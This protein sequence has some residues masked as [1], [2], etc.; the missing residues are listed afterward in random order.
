M[1]LQAV[2][3]AQILFHWLP[4]PFSSPSS[5]AHF[6]LL[7]LHGEAASLETDSDEEEQTGVKST[8]RLEE[9][10][11]GLQPGTASSSPI[12]L[13]KQGFKTG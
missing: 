4:S 11:P 8:S 6:L 7:V 5:E 12:I 13:S 1:S 9:L 10:V 3:C 2:L